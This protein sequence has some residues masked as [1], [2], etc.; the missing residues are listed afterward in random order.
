MDLCFCIQKGIRA[1]KVLMI[2]GSPHK[3]GCTARALAEVA[4]SLKEENIE[5]ELVQVGTE[6]RKGCIGCWSCKKTGRCFMGDL[7]NELADKMKECDGLIVGSPV[8]YAGMSGQLKPVLDRLFMS[9]DTEL[10]YKPA[11]AVISSRRA[12]STS[13]FDDVNRFFTMTSMPIVS[14][15]YWNEVHGR[16]AADVEQ[17]LEGLQ[18]LRLLG[19]NMAWMLKSI[20]AGKKAGIEK[21]EYEAKVSTH[22]IR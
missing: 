6:E 11:A 20:E 17:D 7:V 15:N 14:S 21:P 16:K 13:A 1:M 8:Y 2:N 19:K 4:G 9:A 10:Q 12:G 5:T 22:F 18:T 3:N